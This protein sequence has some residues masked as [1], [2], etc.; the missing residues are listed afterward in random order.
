MKFSAPAQESDLTRFVD[1]NFNRMLASLERLTGKRQVAMH[2]PVA[3]LAVTHPELFV[4]QRRHV[5][6]ELAGAFTRGMTVVDEAIWRSSTS[7]SSRSR[8]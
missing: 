4:F 7:R 2:D 6:V 5:E 1:Q 3:I 8:L